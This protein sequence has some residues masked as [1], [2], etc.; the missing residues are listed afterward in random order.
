[1]K[2]RINPGS[3]FTRRKTVAKTISRKNLPGEIETIN[4]GFS[5]QA[6]LWRIV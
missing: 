1:M 5:L 3:L 2:L 6:E 4:L